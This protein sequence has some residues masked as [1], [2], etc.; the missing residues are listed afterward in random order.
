MFDETVKAGSGHGKIRRHNGEELRLVRAGPKDQTTVS[1]NHSIHPLPRYDGDGN[2]WH[3][4]MQGMWKPHQQGN[5]A[6][7]V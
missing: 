7:R 6:V 5:A 4:K 1:R 3:I 2:A